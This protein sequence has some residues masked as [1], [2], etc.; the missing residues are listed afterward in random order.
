MTLDSAYA[1]ITQDELLESLDLNREEIKVACMKM[2]CTASGATA[3]T[4]AKSGDT[5]TLVITGGARAGTDTIDLSLAANDTIGELITVIEALGDSWVINR[6]C[7][8]AFA[9]TDLYNFSAVSA[10]NRTGE[11]ALYGFNGVSLDNIINAMSRFA[12]SF[13]RRNFI[14][15]SLTEYIDGHSARYLRLS[16]YPVDTAQAYSVILYDYVTEADLETLTDHDDYEIIADKGM[17][18]R[19][20]GWDAS[21][22]LKAWKVS[23]YYG[24]T[25]ATMPEDLKQGIKELCKYIFSLRKKTGLNSE[26]DGIRTTSYQ[27]SDYKVMGIYLPLDL[28]AFLIPYK[29][30]DL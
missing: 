18:Y 2:Y 16:Q 24:Y 14:Q 20:G 23:Y 4:V 19:R 27:R 17:I 7:P 22:N 9:S 21:Q 10:L 28:I 12:V 8:S 29:K 6:L 25:T 3:V 15:T 1:L 11:I 13:C 5:L 26:G 30:M